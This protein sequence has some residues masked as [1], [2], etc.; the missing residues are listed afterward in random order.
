MKQKFIFTWILFFA[1]WG[2]LYAQEPA[3]DAEN[4]TPAADAD[5]SDAVINEFKFHGLVRVRPELKHNYDYNKKTDD[6]Q[7]FIGQKVQ[8]GLQYNYSKNVFARITIQDGR[9]HG[10]QPGSKTGLNTGND[11]T[12]EATDIREGFVEVKK[13]IGPLGLQ[14][15][16]QILAYGDQRLLGG[17]EWTNVGRSFDGIRFKAETKYFD[18]HLFGMVIA[19]DDNDAV[20]NNSHSG[21]GGPGNFSITCTDATLTN[22]QALRPKTLHD[23]YISGWY[24]TIKPSKHLHVD[25]YAI[26]VHKRW[27]SSKKFD[28]GA[29]VA[30]PGA[31]PAPQAVLPFALE[32]E[33][34][35]R[36]KTADDLITYGIRLT[37][38][39]QKKNKAPT[40]YDWSMEYAAQ[41]GHTGETVNPDWDIFQVKDQSGNRL[42]KQKQIYDAS[43]VAVTAGYTIKK[44]LRIGVEYDRG[45]GDPNRG[46]SLSAANGNDDSVGTFNNLFPTNHLFYGQ[47]DQVSWQNLRAYGFNITFKHE[48]YGTLKL[49]AWRFN[50]DKA[51]DSWYNVGGAPVT[52]PILN[53]PSIGAPSF[54]PGK[55]SLS[56]TTEDYSTSSPTNDRFGEVGF[57]KKEL[58][59]E[60]D[61]TYKYDYNEKLSFGFGYSLMLAQN[62]IRHYQDDLAYQYYVRDLYPSLDP[63]VTTKTTTGQT[64][65]GQY[66]FYK[67]YLE[68]TAN[69]RAHF[70]YF[71]TTFK[72]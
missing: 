8:L 2:A 54:W 12:D 69:P 18:S 17:L 56:K 71:M 47:G 6:R 25:L 66:V 65:T 22:C 4:N 27:F 60:Y 53:N 7:E 63:N 45:S 59:I 15:G 16:R 64:Q 57:L 67:E 20:G 35:L 21:S 32:Y 23:A 38:R 34:S 36:K 46:S 48:K 33:N 72:I 62:S 58:F 14:I 52:A 61:L 5:D 26:G 29:I 19:E 39:T 24:N 55:T 10:G 31:A 50:K 28:L 42:Y 30:P 41:R 1:S 37:N 9:V 3:P 44:M 49:A 51:Q 11:L 70:A 13:M 68:P 43:A 40:A